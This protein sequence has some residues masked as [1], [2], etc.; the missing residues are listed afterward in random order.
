MPKISLATYSIVAHKRY[1]PKDPEIIR[2]IGPTSADLLDITEQYLRSLQSRP[3]E[4]ER[5]QAFMRLEQIHRTRNRIYGRLLCG[6][7][8][9]AADLVDV[10]TQ[11]KRYGRRTRDAELVPLYFS[12]EMPPKRRAGAAILQRFGPTGVRS[13]LSNGLSS[14]FAAHA[15]DYIV[16]L[17]PHLPAEVL[18]ALLEGGL[19]AIEMITFKVPRD[20]TDAVHT[21]EYQPEEAYLVQEIRARRGQFLTRP[22]WLR[23]LAARRISAFELPEYMDTEADVIKLRIE[24]N[25]SIRT[26]DFNRLD[27]IRP[28]VDVTDEVEITQGHP[29]FESIDALA[30]DMSAEILKRTGMDA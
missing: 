23:D 5:A 21:E 29:T 19:K 12:F 7:F 11:R 22:Q 30:S 15:P 10:K 4:D 18:A 28:Y 8:G 13:L 6:G 20:V 24:Y 1:Q 2:A 9:Y 14:H 25:G 3:A 26:V 16:S 27:R 17:K